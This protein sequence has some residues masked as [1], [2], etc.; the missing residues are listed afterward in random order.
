[1]AL[2]V[3]LDEFAE[4]ILPQRCV[5]CGRFGAAI[6]HQCIAALARADG[7]RC[8]HC[9]APA[10][11]DPCPRCASAP[12]AF[13]A[14]RARFRF[15]GDVRRALL[16]AKFRGTTLLLRPLAEAAIEAIPEDWQFDAVVPVPLHRS[17]ERE[18]GYN[19]AAIIAKAV[20]RRLDVPSPPD[21]LRRI[22]ATPPQ[23][24]LNAEQR[25]QNL[26]GAFEARA[27]VPAA[28]LLVDDVTTTGAT[29]EVAARALREA[30]VSLVFAIAIARED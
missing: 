17:R 9:W 27:P 15:E 6:H 19:Q 26:L 5:A 2:R 25:R 24:G 12:P 8:S 28:V 14:L 4:A 30:G 1:M 18:R 20:A 13:E 3:L 21:R 10:D 23:A 16:E 11:A 29:F 22:R 7:A